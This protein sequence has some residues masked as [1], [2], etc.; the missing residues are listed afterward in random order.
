MPLP[1]LAPKNGEE[2][3][4]ESEG[5]L[6]Q[7]ENRHIARAERSSMSWYSLKLGF[8]LGMMA[9]AIGCVADPRDG[10]F[11][12]DSEHR[13]GTAGRGPGG[14]GTDGSANETSG[15]DQDGGTADAII[16]RRGTGGAGEPGSDA[17]G[18]TADV[19]ASAAD[20]DASSAD[21]DTAADE[22][23]EPE[24]DGAQD[25][26]SDAIVTD[27]CDGFDCGLGS[28]VDRLGTAVCACDPQVIGERCDRCALGYGGEAC[29]QCATG[30]AS[31]PTEPDACVPD[32][33][34]GNDCSGHGTCR[35]GATGGTVCICD[36][37]FA[38]ADCDGCALGYAGA[39]CNS[40]AE[41][42]ESYLGSC[43]VIGCGGTDCGEH[44]ECVGPDPAGGGSCACDRGYAGVRCDS[45]VASYARIGGECVPDVCTEIECVHGTCE[46]AQGVPSCACRN[47]FTG[48]ACDLCPEGYVAVATGGGMACRNT[49]PTL[50]GVS[51][52]FDAAHLPSFNFTDLGTVALW[53][54][55]IADGSF[56]W[57]QNASTRPPYNLIQRGV[58][59]GGDRDLLATLTDHLHQRAAYTVYIV[60]SWNPAAGNQ[61]LLATQDVHHDYGY[62]MGLVIEV[63]GSGSVRATH[64]G[65]FLGSPGDV[66]EGAFF[67]AGTGRRLVRVQRQ[68]FFNGHAFTVSNGTQ[69]TSVES[70]EL[71][72]VR[73]TICFTGTSNVP[74]EK[75]LHGMLH[76]I[77]VIHG[78]LSAQDRNAIEAYLRVKW[79]L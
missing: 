32:P 74:G 67:G 36:P 59:L 14:A 39:N 7:A 76:E 2:M 15:A 43:A 71:P 23:A 35:A 31:D 70:Q 30:Y 45:C 16:R 22:D 21:A 6:R 42:F 27:V 33:C 4:I 48:A 12:A 20:V 64:R 65:Q 68:P 28:C 60:A 55:R 37:G 56:V 29:D 1:F 44:G 62:G 11:G 58:Q 61:W 34:A 13:E 57:P 75:V 17:D 26:G 24:P 52:W 19:D 41:G 18:S 49:L 5:G 54:N 10:A 50:A 53:R 78:T 9:A 8:A 69:T 38:G 47:G 77:V 66:V 51:A 63:T 46:V 73:P 40:C 72:F 25:A 3:T 79:Q